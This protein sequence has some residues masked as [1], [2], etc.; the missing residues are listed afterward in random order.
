[1]R[2]STTTPWWSQM[3]T[4]FQYRSRYN[5]SNPAWLGPRIMDKLVF[6]FIIL[7]LYLRIGSNF[8]ADNIVNLSSSLFMWTTLPA[9]GAASYVPSIVLGE[10]FAPALPAFRHSGLQY[11]VTCSCT[12]TMYLVASAA[13]KAG[14]PGV[15]RN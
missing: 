10:C 8:S 6:T 4:L 2:R 14:R 5:Y 3:L 15:S 12:C 13:L 11:G 1:M 7:T 9:F